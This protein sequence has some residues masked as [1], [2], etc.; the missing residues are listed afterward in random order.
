[1]SYRDRL[2]IGKYF[3][4]SGKE[5]T[6]HFDDLSRSGSKKSA[7]LEVPQSD[8][9]IVQDLGNTATQF[10]FSLYFFGA[11]Y[12][13]IA[14]AFYDALREIGP[15]TLQHPRWGDISVLAISFSQ[16]EKFVDGI[17]EAQFSVEFV[18][19]PGA[20]SITSTAI[21]AAAVLSAAEVAASSASAVYG[22]TFGNPKLRDLAECRTRLLTSI[23]AIKKS[24]LKLVGSVREIS[25]KIN[26]ATV[27]LE[28]DINTILGTPAAL[29]AAIQDLIFTATSA[30]V[31]IS[32]KISMCRDIL[33]SAITGNPN[34]KAQ[35]AISELL[36]S[37]IS[38][39]AISSISVGTMSSRSEAIDI[40]NR[41]ADM[42]TS[43]RLIVEG[44]EKSAGYAANPDTAQALA[45]ASAQA[46]GYLLAASYNL[47]IER[48]ATLEG[49]ATPLELAYRFY[50]DINRLDELCDQ[51]HW[52]GDRLFIVPAGSE[53]RY[54]AE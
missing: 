21:T 39:A 29:S 46:S 44:A 16:A 30:P 52:Q 54:Y 11:D 40:R 38:A 34:T 23:R 50:G 19:A 10:P 20:Q 28:A 36:A 2:R 22:E 51:N 9:A 13:E 49:A 27:A 45:L 33:E 48:R 37:I 6:F 3:S 1:M 42:Y 15:G 53:A 8:I 43:S 32:E 35:A 12:D 26:G 41:L 47:R 31:S 18:H 24:A 5:F 17:G 14:D 25:Q 7:V 4:P